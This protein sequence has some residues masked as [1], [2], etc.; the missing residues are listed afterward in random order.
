MTNRIRLGILVL[1]IGAAI[2]AADRLTKLWVLN[3]LALYEDRALIPALYPY[4]RVFHTNNTGVAF[5]LF[6]G[7]GS[8]F[9]VVNVAAILAIVYYAFRQ[10]HV[11]LLTLIS[12]GLVLGGAAGNLVDRVLYGHVI[13]FIDVRYSDSVYWPTFNIADSAVVVGVLLLLLTVYLE[14][15]AAGREAEED[16]ATV[17][18]Q[19]LPDHQG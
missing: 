2:L 3:N 8:L 1:L 16:P 5:G 13:D 10:H 12:L 15:R 7:G 19:P 17:E 18:N 6:R 4:L 14:E 9:A 11:S